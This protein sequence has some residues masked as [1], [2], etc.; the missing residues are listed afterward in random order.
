MAATNT[1]FNQ[2]A[3]AIEAIATGFEGMSVELAEVV[4]NTVT[5]NKAVDEI[6]AVSEQSAAGIQET[7]AT[8]E[9]TASSMAEI[10]HSAEH[11][12]EM[13]EQLNALIRQFKL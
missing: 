3:D 6:A 2:I 5:I 7:S 8:I 4:H 9:Q 12:A 1:T 10:K 13:A 11:L